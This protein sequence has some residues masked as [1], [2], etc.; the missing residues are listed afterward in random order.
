MLNKI[1]INKLDT[2]EEK[3][4]KKIYN[5]NYFGLFKNN[6]EKFKEYSIIN[7]SYYNM[8]YKSEK[9]RYYFI[10]ENYPEFVELE[11]FLIIKNIKCN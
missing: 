4:C 5:N 10:K 3:N 6:Y 8:I 9:Y 2:Q 7:G 1:K 11:E